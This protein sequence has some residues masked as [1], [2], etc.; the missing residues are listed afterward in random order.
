MPHF[1]PCIVVSSKVVDRVERGRAPFPGEP[2]LAQAQVIRNDQ[3]CERN[4]TEA[5]KGGRQERNV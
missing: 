3:E 2:N 5:D 4:E 1:T